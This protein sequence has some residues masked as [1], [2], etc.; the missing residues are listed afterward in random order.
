VT[1]DF[2]D[3]E[4]A[5]CGVDDMANL[6]QILIDIADKESA[7][8]AEMDMSAKSAAIAVAY[9][10]DAATFAVL[11]LKGMTMDLRKQYYAEIE[12]AR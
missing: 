8:A 10:R 2:S 11:H 12:R 9:W 5:V 1:A 7:A 4:S 3:L 6:A